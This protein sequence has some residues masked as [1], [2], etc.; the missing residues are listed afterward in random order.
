MDQPALTKLVLRLEA[1]TSRLEDMAQA[2]MDPSS[3]PNGM[4]PGP[5]APTLAAN[6]ADTSGM[7]SEVTRVVSEPLPPALDDFD[8][9]ITGDVEAFVSRSEELGGLVAEQVR[10]SKSSQDSLNSFLFS[11]LRSAK[12]LCSSLQRF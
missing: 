8:S 5:G 10:P 2:T 3:Q 6:N 11:W 9:L 4:V 12:V 7:G 1:A